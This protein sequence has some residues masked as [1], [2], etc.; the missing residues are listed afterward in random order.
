MSRY[1]DAA[2]RELMVTFLGLFLVVALLFWWVLARYPNC[3]S[4][5]LGSVRTNHLNNGV[6]R[7]DGARW[8]PLKLP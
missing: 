8:V 2:N 7:C 4:A 5:E 1:T 6:D 3:T